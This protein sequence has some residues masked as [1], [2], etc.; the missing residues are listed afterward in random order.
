MHFFLLM[1]VFSLFNLLGYLLPFIKPTVFVF[2]IFI[3]LLG[4]IGRILMIFRMV[5]FD[6]A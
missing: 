5:F 2:D 6:V 4:M 1:A 3:M